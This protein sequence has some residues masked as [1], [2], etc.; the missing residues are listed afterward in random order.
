MSLVGHLL[1]G[2]RTG[3]SDARAR[4]EHTRR[5]E[6]LTRLHP[7]PPDSCGLFLREGIGDHILPLAFAPALLSTHGLRIAAVAGK[8]RLAFVADLFSPAPAYAPWTETNPWDW[9]R[10][11]ILAPGSWF[12][13][14][15]PDFE[16]FRA[17]GVSGYHFLDAYRA[18][19]G[20]PP[21][22]PLAFPRLPTTAE[23]AAARAL[24]ADA[25]LTP[26]SIVILCAHSRSTPAPGVPPSFWTD[27]ATAL[28][29]TGRQPVFNL[30]PGAPSPAPDFP[31]LDIP[32][33]LFR[34]LTLEAGAICSVRSG[35]SDLVCDL[36]CHRSVLYARTSFGG[37]PLLVGTTFSRYGLPT[38]SLEIELAPDSAASVIT[39]LAS[40]LA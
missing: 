2:L 24:L 7:L 21:S 40:A 19:L 8:P 18:R 9:E 35:L 12:V 38:P 28:R 29:A 10:G 14:H 15:F 22:T 11:A 23:R 27:L 32:L 30:G 34:A 39:R 20:L 36:P 4:W 1:Y 25:G 26:G 33:P 37:G 13:A 6:T 5:F 17:V 16:L 3:L 31:A